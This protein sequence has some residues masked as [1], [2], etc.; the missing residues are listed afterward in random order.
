MF[1]VKQLDL[2]ERCAD[3]HAFRKIDYPQKIAYAHFRGF[4]PVVQDLAAVLLVL[5]RWD[6]SKFC[7][8]QGA[9]ADIVS[10]ICR[11]INPKTKQPIRYTDRQIRGALKTL[12]ESGFLSIP[13]TV[14]RE[15]RLAKIYRFTP[16]FFDLVK[17]S[18]IKVC[19]KDL[20]RPARALSENT[21]S[22]RVTENLDSGFNIKQSRAIDRTSRVNVENIDHGDAQPKKSVSSRTTLPRDL[23][24]V[25]RQIVHWLS[26]CSMLTGQKEAITICGA[27]LERQSD[28]QISQWVHDWP[29]MIPAER[30]FTV[31]Q[32][33]GY[34]R[35]LSPAVFSA[36]C[37]YTP[38]SIDDE[39]THK[40]A[41]DVDRFRAALLL[42]EPYDGPGRG[43]IARFRSADE[44]T[45]ELMSLDLQTKIK[46]GSLIFVD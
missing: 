3:R 41:F 28:E 45:K 32:I 14:S 2:R 11:P 4:R 20:L 24:P 33:I 40:P 8:F 29:E 7:E 6:Y 19:D 36:D 22:D 18:P 27:F 38:E 1:A 31:R 30:S 15:E 34:L 35:G 26:A 25:L 21:K 9:I 5:V 46:T 13:R 44:D 37:T 43:F 10:D 23:S 39:P 16:A 42:G 17:E 12:E